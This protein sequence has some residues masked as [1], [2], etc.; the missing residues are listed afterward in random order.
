MQSKHKALLLVDG[1]VNI[2]LGVLLLLFPVGIV[3]VLGLPVTNTNFYPTI[4]GAVLLGIG[5]ALIVEL[6]GFGKKVRGLS[7]G[8]AIVINII[9]AFVLILWL[10]FGSLQIPARGFIILWVIGLLVFFIGIAEV[11]AKSWDYDK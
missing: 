10:L 9:G 3:D 8:G 6:I 7:L 1:I 5:I 2:I 4:L 11:I